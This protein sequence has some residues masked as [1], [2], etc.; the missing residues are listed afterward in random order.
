MNP[1][2]HEGKQEET[3]PLFYGSPALWKKMKQTDK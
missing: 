3:N 1:P 2:V